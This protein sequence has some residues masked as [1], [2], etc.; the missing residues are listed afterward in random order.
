MQ[1]FL[2]PP[3]VVHFHLEEGDPVVR[4]YAAPT[5]GPQPSVV[6]LL[7][8]GELI[9]SARASR[10]SKPAAAASIRHGWCGFEIH[11][12]GKA[13][14]VGDRVVLECAGSGAIL[15]GFEMSTELFRG[16]A[17][18]TSTVE[19]VLRIGSAGETFENVD[20]IVPFLAWHRQKH[21]TDQ[22]IEATYQTVL[23]RWPEASV[24]EH[25]RGALNTNQDLAKFLSTLINSDEFR[26]RAPHQPPGPFHQAFRLDRGLIG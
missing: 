1:D 10:F 3:V 23:G 17:E 11:G 13:F 2:R 16:S 22:L 5:S 15:H 19:E 12:L 8:D 25:W 26:S 21:G 9:E 6:N 24:F 7:S 20:Q 18:R 14:A 4:G